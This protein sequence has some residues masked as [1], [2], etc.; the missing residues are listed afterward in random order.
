MLELSSF[1]EPGEE[2]VAGRRQGKLLPVP[3]WAQACCP[4]PWMPGRAHGAREAP[5]PAHVLLG[6]SCGDSSSAVT[7]THLLRAKLGFRVGV[8]GGF[9]PT[10]SQRPVRVGRGGVRAPGQPQEGRLPWDDRSV[11]WAGSARP[12]VLAG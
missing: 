11:W 9:Q 6:V 10:F 8:E 1:Q 2:K 4:R 3:G 7:H 12:E 5:R